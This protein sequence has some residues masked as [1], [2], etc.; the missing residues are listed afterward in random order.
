MRPSGSSSG[1][2]ASHTRLTPR[3]FTSSTVF[4]SLEPR[5]MPALLTRP[6]RGAGSA[7]KRAIT[8]SRAATTDCSPGHINLYQIKPGLPFGVHTTQRFDRRCT[9]GR[10]PGSQQNMKVGMVLQNGSCRCQPDSLVR[11]GYQYTFDVPNPLLLMRQALPASCKAVMQ[12][13]PVRK[14]VRACS[15]SRRISLWPMAGALV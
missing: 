10:V 15:T 2:K 12:S 4:A 7:P 11:S 14:S 3:V 9:Q 8:A 1:K 13:I 6:Y 5:P